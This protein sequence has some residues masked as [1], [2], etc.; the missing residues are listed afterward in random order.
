[1]IKIIQERTY[2]ESAGLDHEGY[3]IVRRK[4]PRIGLCDCGTEV[5]LECF[6]NTCDGCSRDYNSAGQ[7]LAPREQWGW[8]TGESV[9]DILAIDGM[10]TDELLE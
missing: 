10:T 9:D 7:E 4:D 1:M 8:D 5:E 2:H 3:P 6:T